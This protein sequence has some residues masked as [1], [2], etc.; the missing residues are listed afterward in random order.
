MLLW[1]C[2][3]DWVA[4]RQTLDTLDTACHCRLQI[5]LLAIRPTVSHQIDRSTAL[6][7]ALSLLLPGAICRCR[8]PR[9]CS[10]TKP[11]EC[12]AA[13]VTPPA[14]TAAASCAE[15]CQ[16]HCCA[17]VADWLRVPCRGHCRGR[18][19][20]CTFCCDWQGLAAAD[21]EGAAGIARA[22][23]PGGL[24]CPSSTAS[25]PDPSCCLCHHRAPRTRLGRCTQCTRSPDPPPTNSVNHRRTPA[26][27]PSCSC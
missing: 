23:F 7:T 20:G 5:I 10:E 27:P 18:C 8:Q 12:S 4:A 15:P 6:A 21:S 17:A 25:A 26:H 2:R 13:P 16:T 3:G 19:W 22:C 11:K 24:P 9:N 14:L 1:G